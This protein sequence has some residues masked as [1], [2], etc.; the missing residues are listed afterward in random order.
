[1][2]SELKQLAYVS[3]ATKPMDEAA[4][5][6]LLEESRQN[7][8]R[9]N[10]TGFLMHCDGNFFQV[11]EGSEQAIEDLFQRLMRDIRHHRVTCI[12]RR[13]ISERMFAEWSMAFRSPEAHVLEKVPGYSDFVRSYFRLPDAVPGAREGVIGADIQNIILAFRNQLL[14]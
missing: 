9:D 7:N 5:L 13:D 11:I 6:A 2:S 1:M 4:L 10:I 12:L 3:N 14:N 8:A